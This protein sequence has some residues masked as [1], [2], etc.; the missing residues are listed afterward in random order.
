MTEPVAV[1]ACGART[2]LGANLAASAAAVR[3]GMSAV[4]THRA[5]VDAAGEPMSYAADTFLAPHAPVD[6]RLASL[7]ATALAE[8]LAPL[9]GHVHGGALPLFL[10]LPEPKPGLPPGLGARLATSIDQ[11]APHGARVTT[12]VVFPYGHAA[13]LMALEHGWRYVQ[14]GHAELCVVGGVD[15]YL[16]PETLEWLDAEGQ[17]MSARH[18]AG[19]PPGEAAGFCLL[20]SARAT[21]RYGLRAPAY[22]ARVATA[23]EACRIKTETVCVGLGLTQAIRDALGAL[24]PSQERVARTYCD[25]NGERYRSEEFT[26]AVLRTHKAFVDANDYVHPAD[27]WGDVGA[28][29]GPLLAGLAVTAAARGYANGANV[30][31]WA[32]SEGGQRSAAVLRLAPRE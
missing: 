20:A 17:L 1:V 29:T 11:R 5:P 8:A 9:A 13:G 21:R 2:P 18:R 23:L 16:A 7:A 22:V 15:S 6:E 26:Y 30:L 32:S 31:L 25:L 12:A 28:A 14:D 24:R 19:F 27:G 4:R 3:A 10:G